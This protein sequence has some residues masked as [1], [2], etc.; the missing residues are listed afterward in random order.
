MLKNIL[1]EKK[2]PKTNSASHKTSNK[3]SIK[4]DTLKKKTY[5]DRRKG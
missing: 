4:R 5:T 1:N 2:K 3:N